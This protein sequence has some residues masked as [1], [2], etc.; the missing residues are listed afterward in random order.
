M[1]FKCGCSLDNPIK[2]INNTGHLCDKHKKE[3]ADTLLSYEE[4]DIIEYLWKYKGT[5]LVK[6]L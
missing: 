5:L 6:S 4:G 1:K 3:F 2:T